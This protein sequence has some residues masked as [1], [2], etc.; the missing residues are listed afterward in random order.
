MFLR[1]TKDAIFPE[2]EEISRLTLQS[3][4]KKIKDLNIR[5]Q[6]RFRREYLGQLVEHKKCGRVL[7]INIGD[8]VLVGA[9]NKKRYQWPIA[10]VEEVI[11]SPDDEVRTAK[12]RTRA[13]CIIRPLQRLY[14]LEMSQSNSRPDKINVVKSK[15][16]VSSDVVSEP[17]EEEEEDKATVTRSGRISK[18]PCR[19]NGWNK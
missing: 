4:W 8:V 16:P 19:Y 10:R 11:L 1:G 6:G 14:P 12:L 7:P 13:G 9:D 2:G 17:E 18:K 3:E 15:E 5:L